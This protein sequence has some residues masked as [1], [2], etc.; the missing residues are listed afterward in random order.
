MDIHMP[1]QASRSL[2]NLPAVFKA[3]SDP[4]RLRLLSLLAGGE[5]CVCHLSVALS[6][7]QPKV[8]RHLAY[9]KKAGLVTATREG[10]WM[11]YAWAESRDAAVRNVMSGLHDSF[12]KD[13]RLAAERKKLKRICCL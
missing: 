2:A 7:V 11:H 5:V 4:T 8:S 6:M 3:L 13:S 12:A 10:Q 1:A 9:L